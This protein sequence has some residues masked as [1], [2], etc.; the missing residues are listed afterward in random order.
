MQNQDTFQIAER[1]RAEYHFVFANILATITTCVVNGQ[2]DEA[3]TI[4]IMVY[5]FA[6]A[7]LPAHQRKQLDFEFLE[8]GYRDKKELYELY[9]LM[10]IAMN[11]AG[12]VPVQ[13]DYT[14]TLFG[15]E[16]KKR[17]EEG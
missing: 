1:N 10:A 8:R 3:R 12:L 11:K 2:M 14:T 13:K 6:N 15:S 9:E 17:I 4:I 16:M 5:T 7:Q